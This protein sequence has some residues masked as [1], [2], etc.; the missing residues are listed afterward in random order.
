MCCRS[1]FSKV[2]SPTNISHEIRILWLLRNFT[3]HICLA[4]LLFVWCFWEKADVWECL[5]YTGGATVVHV[6]I[7]KYTYIYTHTYAYTFAPVYITHACDETFLNVKS[8]TNWPCRM[9]VLLILKICVRHL[10]GICARVA[11]ICVCSS[12]WCML[13]NATHGWCLCVYMYIY[14]YIY[15]C[16]CK[17][18][19][20]Y[21]KFWC[22][23]N[24]ATHGWC[25]CVYMY[26]CMCFYVY[27]CQYVY[28]Y[29]YIHMYVYVYT[30]IWC[31]LN[32]A[33]RGWCLCVYIYI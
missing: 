9:S 4:I 22:M 27:T 26:I 12:I 23:L 24:N 17:Y 3:T 32:N 2:S 28:T 13:N 18:T 1:I 21:T 11:Q 25:L 7:Y 31:M 15:I 16:I 6:Y 14:V 30:N 19:C 20:T 10:W 8:L 33:T 29:G 5:P